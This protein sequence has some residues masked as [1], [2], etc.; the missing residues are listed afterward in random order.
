MNAGHEIR[1][2]W[3]IVNVYSPSVSVYF[4]HITDIV[5]IAITHQGHARRSQLMT[6][7]VTVWGEN[8]HEQTNDVVARI[9]PEGMHACIADGLNEDPQI[10]ARAVTLQ[11]PEQG[12]P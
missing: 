7:K 10:E 2:W 3:Q 9:Y 1:R 12:L 4:S 6:I 5:G 8:V 11:D